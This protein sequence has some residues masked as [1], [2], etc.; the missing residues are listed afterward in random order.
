MGVTGLGYQGGGPTSYFTSLKC[1]AHEKYLLG[2]PGFRC[3]WSLLCFF[4]PLKCES[5]DLTCST[6]NG[7]RHDVGA[8]TMA[9]PT[10]AALG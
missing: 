6:M 1:V 9:P 8:A 10:T 4:P 7:S 3:V 5:G 2:L